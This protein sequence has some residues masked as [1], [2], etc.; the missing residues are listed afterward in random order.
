MFSQVYAQESENHVYSD[1]Y[2]TNAP[3]LEKKLNVNCWTNTTYFVLVQ[4]VMSRFH[5]DMISAILDRELQATI[6]EWSV[7]C[8]R[9]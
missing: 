3:I 1:E 2:T 4:Q 8:R 9:Q 7:S 6:G 5:A